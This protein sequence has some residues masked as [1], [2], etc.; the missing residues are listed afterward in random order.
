[1]SALHPSLKLL[2]SENKLPFFCKRCIGSTKP[3][4]K[5]KVARKVLWGL[6]LN[7]NKPAATS[8][9]YGSFIGSPWKTCTSHFTIP[10]DSTFKLNFK[11]TEVRP[12]IGLSLM[13]CLTGPSG[14]ES[15]KK[16]QFQRIA[17]RLKNF[18]TLWLLCS[19]NGDVVAFKALEFQ[20]LMVS[21]W[22]P[23]AIFSAL[24][25]HPNRAFVQQLVSL[26]MDEESAAIV[27][28]Q[29][30]GAFYDQLRSLE[31]ILKD[32]AGILVPTIL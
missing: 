13:P 21:Q 28:K 17:K 22:Y 16:Y 31:K 18:W 8:K 2:R 11:V 14:G 9:N 30:M 12:K 10:R 15:I 6:F 7:F 24:R 20:F 29:M 25:Q 4:A 23:N 3:R 19:F 27:L 1:M 5:K 26:V 32:E